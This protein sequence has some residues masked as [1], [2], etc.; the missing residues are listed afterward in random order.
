MPEEQRWSICRWSSISGVHYKR[1]VSLF[2]WF[3]QQR[4]R[5]VCVCV[6][7]WR[8]VLLFIHQKRPIAKAKP[9]KDPE[10]KHLGR[11]HE[12]HNQK[13]TACQV[14][15]K[16]YSVF[17]FWH[18]YNLLVGSSILSI[19]QGTLLIPIYASALKFLVKIGMS[20]EIIQ[21]LDKMKRGFF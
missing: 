20:L 7:I 11:L 6:C 15:E 8:H 16:K 19:F 21:V 10:L 3:V 9:I 14:K 1:S 2:L 5:C 13:Q 12:A 17:N 18:C 4:T